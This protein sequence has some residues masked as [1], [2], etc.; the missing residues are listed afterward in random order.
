MPALARGQANEPSIVNWFLTVSGVSTDGF[1][2]G[3]R[4]FDIVGGLPGTQVFP[5]TPGEYEDVTDAPGKF[6][7]GSYY[8]YDNGAGTGYTPLLT[9]S[10]GTH[11]IEWR[12]KISAGAAYQAGYEDF[13]VLVESAGGST[14]TYCSV[15]D[16]RNEGLTDPPY[17]DAQVLAYI[18]I[19]Q[20]FLD[21]ACRQ[22]FNP[23]T[24]V[25]EFDG[26][27]SD[28]IHFG[29]PIIAIEYLQINERG[30]DLEVEYYKV[31]SDRQ[32]YQDRQNPRIKLVNNRNNRDIFTASYGNQIFKKG[33]KNQIV[34]GTFGYTEADNTTPKLIKRALTKLVIEKLT[35]PV[36]LPPGTIAGGSATPP[37]LGN[38]LEEWTDSHRMKYTAPGGDKKPTAAGFSGITND[39]EILAIIKMFKAPMGIATPAN[40]SYR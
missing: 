14:D 36:Y 32:T 31:Y 37:I 12:W 26:T 25:I 19:W 17:D 39:P 22:W 4:I 10:V 23:R 6:G 7:V 11:R 34:K 16:I 20:S 28:A 15:L 29:V 2:V 5:V 8:A 30:V 38:L 40:F 9:A 24:M 21:R 33:R 18:E 35:T 3:F 13:E 27:D 1:E